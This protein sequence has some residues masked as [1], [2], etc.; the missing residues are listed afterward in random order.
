MPLPVLLLNSTTGADTNSGAGPSTPITG[1][2]A[3]T[4]ADG[5]TVTLPNA[6]LTAVVVDGS[7]AIL[8]NSR[9]LMIT[10][11]GN[12]GTP[13]AFVTVAN[14]AGASLTGLTYAIG[15][16]RQTFYATASVYNV[17]L[18]PGW[19][20]FLESGYNENTTAT[21]ITFTCNGS[22]T[23]NGYIYLLGAGRDVVT[24]RHNASTFVAN[25][26]FGERWFISGITF[27]NSSPAGSGNQT[28]GFTVNDQSVFQN[29]RVNGGC[30][31][32]S[33]VAMITVRNSLLFNTI[34]YPTFG[35]FSA[36][37]FG[38]N[39]WGD[40]YVYGNFIKGL[41]LGIRAG[42][43]STGTP[44]VTNSA[45]GPIVVG[46]K[47][48]LN[49]STAGVA[50]LGYGEAAF[51]WYGRINNNIINVTSPNST[52]ISL[53]R[54]MKATRFFCT[55]NCI[56]GAATGITVGATDLTKHTIYKNN[57]WNVTTQISPTT[58]LLFGENTTL[59]PNLTITAEDI[60]VGNTAVLNILNHFPAPTGG[61]G[62]GLLLP[63]P[64]NGG[65][66]A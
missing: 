11:K 15:G 46:N 20:V 10:A 55:N 29:C 4:S 5:L 31:F 66:S 39:A 36:S 9:I 52:G 51:W 14:S 3:S 6:D 27:V 21:T 33:N 48:L 59:N 61:G 23:S 63:R 53:D 60:V 54:D 64:M 41:A 57:F 42:T 62:G 49:T 8:V 45:V 16:K 22:A 47:I 17:S 44:Q 25:V 2:G 37:A 1:T 13:T 32:N 7:H 19:T 28:N 40:S 43:G 56:V 24:L 12:S 38:V 34:I 18:L 35:T 50:I 26:S 65:Y 58:F 30:P